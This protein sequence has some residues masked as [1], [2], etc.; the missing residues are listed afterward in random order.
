MKKI[1]ELVYTNTLYNFISSVMKDF[2]ISDNDLLI[3]LTLLY[4][5]YMGCKKGYK[6][7]VWVKGFIEKRRQ[8]KLLKFVSNNREE[9]IRI[10][11]QNN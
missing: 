6:A 2:G 5:G 1:F 9:I 3:I 8:E 10:L 7:F 11:L 4:L